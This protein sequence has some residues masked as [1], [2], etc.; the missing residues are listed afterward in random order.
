M[1]YYGNLNVY[2]LE[3]IGTHAVTLSVLVTKGHRFSLIHNILFCDKK[4]ILHSISLRIFL[5]IPRSITITYARR[6]LKTY[7]SSS[8][9]AM[10][11]NC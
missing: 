8:N 5:K 9:W 1:R 3:C 4:L 7:Y 10:I 11:I 2:F 6:K